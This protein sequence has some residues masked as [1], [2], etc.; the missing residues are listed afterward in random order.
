MDRETIK[1]KWIE[2]LTRLFRE[3]WMDDNDFDELIINELMPMFGGW[4]KLYADIQTGVNNGYT[5]DQQFSIME[6]LL[7]H[8]TKGTEQ[9][10][11]GA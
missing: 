4:D 8:G 11:E 1:K 7:F 2:M 10:Q 6:K 3:E 5:E 9:L